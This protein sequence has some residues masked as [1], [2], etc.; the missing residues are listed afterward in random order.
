MK[1]FII[2]GALGGVLLLAGLATAQQAEQPLHYT[3]LFPLLPDHVEGFVADTPGG[4]TAA[5]AGFRLTEVTRMYHKAE[6]GD[7]AWAAIKITDGAGN[8]SLAAARADA[9]RVSDEGPDGYDKTFTLD[10]YQAIERYTNARKE[11]SLIV[12]V[13]GRYL[14]E[15]N[16]L[17]LDSKALQTLWK[18]VDAHRLEELTAS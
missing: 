7:A 9:P 15:I 8:Q 16:V 6:D 2:P 17:G 18:Q 14:V 10:G 3:R 5:A 12:F 11:G 1:R 13:A 4:S